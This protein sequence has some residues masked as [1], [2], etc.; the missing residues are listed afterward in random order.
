MQNRQILLLTTVV[1]I[2]TVTLPYAASSLVM[3]PSVDT[4]TPAHTTAKAHM[5]ESI[6]YRSILHRL[7]ERAV[8]VGDLLL[9]GHVR[10]RLAQEISEEFKRISSDLILMLARQEELKMAKTDALEGGAP[11]AGRAPATSAGAGIA[12]SLTDE[13]IMVEK[14]KAL[15]EFAVN[16]EIILW[17]LHQERITS[18]PGQAIYDYDVGTL[19]LILDYTQTEGDFTLSSLGRLRALKVLNDRIDTQKFI[20]V[21]KETAE[22]DLDIL[23][24]RV[25]DLVN[26][27]A[28]ISVTLDV[29]KDDLSELFRH[30]RSLPKL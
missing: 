30:L 25:F 14:L 7:R 10:H 4:G 3:P 29:K 1:N 21:L 6:M 2:L 9:P 16:Q 13:G 27:H 12:A 11:S 5:E 18:T 24:E 20:T 22:E 28:L 15:A 8:R 19:R 23:V 17:K 26:D